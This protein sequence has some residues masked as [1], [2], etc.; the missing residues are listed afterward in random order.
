M[1]VKYIKVIQSDAGLEF[2][3]DKLKKLLKDKNI[4]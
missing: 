1:K 2:I 4:K 3:N